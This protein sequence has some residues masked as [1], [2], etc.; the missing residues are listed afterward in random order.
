MAL[1]LLLVADRLIDHAHRNLHSPRIPKDHDCGQLLLRRRLAAV[2]LLPSF[3]ARRR[4]LVFHAEL[5]VQRE[6]VG[7]DLQSWP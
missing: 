5:C 2:W 3:T 1:L 4:W 6:E 7:T